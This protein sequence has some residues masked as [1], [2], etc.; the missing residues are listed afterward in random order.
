MNEEK[1]FTF[2]KIKNV[3]VIDLFMNDL[4]TS[5]IWFKYFDGQFPVFKKLDSIDENNL[6]IKFFSNKEFFTTVILNNENIFE[7][8]INL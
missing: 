3:D 8:F 5:N 7:D 1:R 2:I 4:S 6:T